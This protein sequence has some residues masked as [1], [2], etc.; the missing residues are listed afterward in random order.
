MYGVP[1]S[2]SVIVQHGSIQVLAIVAFVAMKC[3]TNREVCRGP[4]QQSDRGTDLTIMARWL[5]LLL[6]LYQIYI[7]DVKR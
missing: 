3:C 7:P 5:R 4:Q 6:S 1:D 2:S